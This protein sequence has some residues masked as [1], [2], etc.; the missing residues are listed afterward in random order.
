MDAG[1]IIV[2]IVMFVVGA[3]ILSAIIKSG[4]RRGIEDVLYK[5]D[6]QGQWKLHPWLLDAVKE[7]AAETKKPTP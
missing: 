2:Q 5:K 4:V 3:L 6:A 7:A 1:F